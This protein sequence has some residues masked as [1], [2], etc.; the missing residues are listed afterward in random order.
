MLSQLINTSERSTIPL[1]RIKTDGGTQM[2]ATLDPDTVQEYL[3]AMQPVGWGDFPAVVVYYDGKDHWLADGFHRVEAYRLAAANLDQPANVPADVRSGTRRDA[4]LHAAGANASHGLRRTNA[5]KRRAV[6]TLLRDDDWRH[7]SN[8]EIARR[9]AVA[10][11][12][13][14]NIRNELELSAQIAQIDDRTVTRNGSTYTQ[15]TANVGATRTL[16]SDTPATQQPGRPLTVEQVAEFIAAFWPQIALQRIAD[17]P[18]PPVA[19]RNEMDGNLGFANPTCRGEYSKGKMRAWHIDNGALFGREPD[20]TWTAFEFVTLTLQSLP[21]RSSA[22]S[23]QQSPISNPAPVRGYSVMDDI[24]LRKEPDAPLPEWAEEPNDEEP[25]FVPVSQRD[26]YDSDEWYTPA[27]YIEA[28]RRAMGSI[29]L[30]PATCEMA[31]TVVQADVYLTKLDN[32]LA[33]KW[34]RETVWLNPPYSNSQAWIDKL[35]REVDGVFVKQ[36]IVLVNNATETAW[37]QSLLAR[38]AVVCFPGRR[39]Q[40]WRHDHSN[41]GARQGQAIFY[42]GPNAAAF[43]TEFQ[44]F[45]T[46]MRRV[47]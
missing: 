2:R 6:E 9:C 5:D 27:D 7:W 37:F 31:Q 46:L 18:S 45:G 1:E 23:N 11:S 40:F 41:V 20:E 44:Q 13:V 14:R 39:L 42:F 36:A 8:R 26:D 25:A 35:L 28:A 33:A 43:V 21:P 34:L 17:A 12:S 16:A 4:I 38:S 3:D 15:N 47:S 10:E 22:I 30:D 19:I 24:A 29:D 32:G